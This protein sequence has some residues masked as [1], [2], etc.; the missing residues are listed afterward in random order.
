MRT[1]EK[2]ALARAAYGRAVALARKAATAATWRRALAASRYLDA[3]LREH[4]RGLRRALEGTSG[5]SAATRPIAR[6][7][8]GAAADRRSPGPD[9][10]AAAAA[11]HLEAWIALHEELA[12]ARRLTAR[13]RAL[14][15][16]SRA[17]CAE[18]SD[19]VATCRRDGPGRRAATCTGG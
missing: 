6:R 14:V 17:L 12:R 8:R 2:L 9:A 4:D 18:L 11:A 5:R 19:A 15:D 3:A 1:D 10:A 13:A 16:E 7:R